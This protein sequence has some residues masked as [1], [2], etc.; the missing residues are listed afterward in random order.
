MI[1]DAVRIEFV[2][3]LRADA[4][5]AD[6]LG[7]WEP[8]ADPILEA[9]VVA[10]LPEAL[11]HW[12]HFES[13][14]AVGST[15]EGTALDREWGPNARCDERRSLPGLAEFRERPDGDL[16]TTSGL[17]ETEAV[18]RAFREDGYSG[19]GKRA[20]NEFQVKEHQ[21]CRKAQYDALGRP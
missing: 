10:H 11:A 15:A 1:V 7:Q 21:R 2:Q 16:S 5:H 13:S 19:I 17:L 12:K 14:P 18:D 20:V 9:Q 6:V 8:H 3:P 4:E